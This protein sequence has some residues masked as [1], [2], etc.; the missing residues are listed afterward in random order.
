MADHHP[1]RVFLISIDNLRSD[2]IGANRHKGALSRFDIKRLPATPTL[3]KIA[4]QG[5][6]F[7]RCFSGAPY[8]TASHATIL[9]GL[10]PAHHGIREY[11]RTPL[12]ESAKTLFQYFKEQGYVTVLAT[13]FPILLGPILGFTRDVDHY[14]EEDD[15]SVFDLLK[16]LGTEKV[17]CFWH[18]G[19]VHNPFGL[20]SLDVDGEHFTREVQSLADR[21]GVA[22]PT[23]LGEEWLERDR[24]PEERILR[25]WYF[26][27]TDLMYQQGRYDELM[28]LYA[29]GVEYF[30]GHRLKNVMDGIEAARLL[31]DSLLAITGDHGEEYSERAFGHFNGLWD[32]IVNVPLI[33]YGSSVQHGMVS[34]AVCRTADIAPTL[35][36]YAGILPQAETRFD[37][38]SL[39]PH[40]E[41]DFPLDLVAIGEATFGYTERIRNFLEQ[42]FAEGRLLESGIMANTHLRFTR[43]RRWKLVMRADVERGA[44]AVELFDVLSDPMEKSNV[45]DHY[46]EAVK[47]L[48]AEMSRITD[49]VDIEDV[50]LNNKQVESVARALI[51]MGY[52]RRPDD[53]SDTSGN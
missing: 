14:I 34:D 15:G 45:A 5:A 9:T 43:D 11:F 16:T 26:R 10:Y 50:S 18:F 23:E 22:R 41:S 31:D 21:V 4:G 52:L 51:N 1:R 44:E 12:A 20:T 24:T 13:D 38:I 36:D 29:A 25:Q 53:G 37:G 47:V 39:R 42:C 2:C 3:D 40:I 46:P 17:F 49:S 27:C 30:D 48:R 8:T 33:L 6:F 28:N 19:S 32:G 7:T 35:L